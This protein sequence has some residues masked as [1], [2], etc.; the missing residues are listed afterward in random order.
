MLLLFSLVYLTRL[1][2]L[3]S[4]A[5]SEGFTLRAGGVSK[6]KGRGGGGGRCLSKM[7]KNT[8]FLGDTLKSILSAKAPAVDLLR[9]ITLTTSLVRGTKTTFLT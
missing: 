4:S 2:Y 9:L 7:L 8:V 1:R 6:R 3:L 5:I